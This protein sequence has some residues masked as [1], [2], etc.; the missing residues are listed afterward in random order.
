MLQSCAEKQKAGNIV[1]SFG[2]DAVTTQDLTLALK[3]IPQP[4]QYEY[5]TEEGRRMLVDMMID[6]KLMS[7]EAVKA[8]L[9]REA[10][11]KTELN[12]TSDKSAVNKER[13]L[14]NAYVRYRVK[15]MQRVTDAAVENYFL[16]HKNEFSV[17]ERIKVKRI[18]FDKKD[19][20]QDAREAFGKGM[21]FEEYKQKNPGS[22][23][24]IDTLWLQERDDASEMERAARLLKTGEISDVLVISS[25][26]CM[27]RIE[28]KVPATNKEIGDVRETL[29]VRLQNDKE[30]ELIENIR[31]D[32]RKGLNITINKG[33]LESYE[34]KECAERSAGAAMQDKHKPKSKNNN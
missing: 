27:V 26:F 20:A 25:G 32:L 19:K 2:N 21:L 10:E 31:K 18:I 14:G 29:K 16:S 34:C 6:W 11:I 33:T 24:T 1:A 28:E 13:V 30:R 15:Q 5:L 23:I 4:E 12:S 17:P 7:R 9:D 3:T 22:K 8:G